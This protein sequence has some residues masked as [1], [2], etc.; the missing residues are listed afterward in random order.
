MPEDRY[1]NRLGISVTESAAGTLSFQELV[2][3]VG[4]QTK[5]GMLIDEISYFIPQSTLALLLAEADL[6]RFGITSSTGVT[7]LED[8]TDSRILHS[9]QLTIR[10]FGTP[11]NAIAFLN[12]IV[13]QFFPSIIHAHIR[14]FLGIQSA[15]IASAATIRTRVLWRFVDLTDREIAELV[16]ATLLSA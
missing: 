12:P 16:Q 1:A 4:F 8:V 2:T 3:G 7:D 10:G 5:K 15:S 13:F 9:G 6:V 11:A 14:I